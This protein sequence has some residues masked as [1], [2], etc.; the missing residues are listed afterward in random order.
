MGFTHGGSFVIMSAFDGVV[1]DVK[2][3]R[4]TDG[5]KVISWNYNAE[6]HQIWMASCENGGFR[7]TASHITDDI[8]VLEQPSG[9]VKCII[10]QF[11]GGDHQLWNA[12]PVPSNP[13]VFFIQNVASGMAI[14]NM[15]RGNPLECS[16]FNEHDP[17]LQWRITPAHSM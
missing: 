4:K 6:P 1:L 9:A 2:K 13:E 3:Q 17:N 8:K 14:R 12:F 11:H 16:A 15:G 7:L 5:A 10:W